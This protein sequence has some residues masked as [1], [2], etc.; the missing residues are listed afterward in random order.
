MADHSRES[1]MSG[2]EAT[3]SQRIL[4]K[5]IKGQETL[6]DIKMFFQPQSTPSAYEGP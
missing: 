4:E 5:C 6:G 3:S 1:R 2:L